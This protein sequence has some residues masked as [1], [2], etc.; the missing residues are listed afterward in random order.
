MTEREQS[1]KKDGTT[2]INLIRVIN[3]T[4]HISPVDREKEVDYIVENPTDEEFEFLYLPLREFQR[5]LKVCD[6]DDRI[7][8]IYPN[9]H[10]KNVIENLKENDE[11]GYQRIQHQFKQAEYKLL[12]QL[13]PER[14]LKPGTM[15]TIRLSYEE[16]DPVKFYSV[17]DPTVTTGWINQWEKKLFKIPAFIANQERFP[18]HP[19]DEFIV[20]VGTPDYAVTGRSIFEGPEPSKEIYENG[21]NDET[22]VIS[23]RS[24]GADN[25]RYTLNV[26]YDLIPNSRNLMR[27][28]ALYWV[29]A[30]FVGII[31]TAF[32]IFN[33]PT[34]APLVGQAV[35]AGFIT[36]TIGLIFALDEGWT[37]RYRIMS[38]IPLLL[39]G[40]AWVHW[41]LP[42]ALL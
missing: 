28:L 32:P 33:L 8:N 29:L 18:G 20:V 34:W 21:L 38:A 26:E 36:S 27:G 42:N 2:D 23:V 16:S 22:R 5:N 40:M 25:G 14:P 9:Q 3:R 11:E 13:P 15:R 41:A 17:T 4:I 35:S 31:S 19:H 24:P 7:L 37:E 6:E 39:H 1:G 30:V 12:I 10:V